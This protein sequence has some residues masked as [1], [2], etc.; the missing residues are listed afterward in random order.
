MC[1]CVFV[2]Q[3]Y[4]MPALHVPAVV[5]LSGCVLCAALCAFATEEK[6]YLNKKYLKIYLNKK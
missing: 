3:M 6:C 5:H 2:Y 1:M 4:L